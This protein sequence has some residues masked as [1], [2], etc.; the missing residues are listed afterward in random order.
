MTYLLLAFIFYAILLNTSALILI[1]Y[2]NRQNSADRSQKS[3]ITNTAVSVIETVKINK[4]E[5]YSMLKTY[6]DK[7]TEGLNEIEKQLLLD[8]FTFK[9]TIAKIKADN[10]E[11]IA[12]FDPD[13]KRTRKAKEFDYSQEYWLTDS[14]PYIKVGRNKLGGG[15]GKISVKA[16]KPEDVERMNAWYN[17][18]N[19]H[20]EREQLLSICDCGGHMR[21][22]FK[23]TDELIQDEEDSNRQIRK[24]I[25][26][27]TCDNCGKTDIDE[28][29]SSGKYLKSAEF[30]PLPLSESEETE[31]EPVY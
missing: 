26:V 23:R 10:A 19:P 31:L 28:K 22:E 5:D 4:V 12:E 11:L 20:V 17:S 16:I 14:L 27:Y 29:G 6:T 30:K 15:N 3:A 9:E 21:T 18:R 8:Y 24:A 13:K 25:T 1:T 7:S 2:L